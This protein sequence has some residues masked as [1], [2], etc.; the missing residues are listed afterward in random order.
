VHWSAFD[1]RR[2]TFH[3]HFAGL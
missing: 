3:L 2:V 1:F